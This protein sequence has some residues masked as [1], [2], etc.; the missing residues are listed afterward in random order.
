LD[1]VLAVLFMG[2]TLPTEEEM[3]R[4]PLLV[5]HHNIMDALS[6]LRL[7]HYD[8]EDIEIST[9]NLTTYINGKAP[10]AIVHQSKSSN[11]VPEG[12][13]VFDN[14]DMDSTTE[15]P[16]PVVV[17]GLVREQLDS[18]SVKVQKTMAAHHFKADKS[19]LAI[20]HALQPESIYNNPV[21]YL[22]MF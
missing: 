12:T 3:K 10:V 6:W 11:K 21:L 22:S 17:H 4:T 8:Y 13:S 9:N 16:C 5:H 20:G 2:P 15:G 18:M 7:N 1:K 14:D 19:V